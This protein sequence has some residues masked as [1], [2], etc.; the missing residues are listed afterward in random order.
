MN[1]PVGEGFDLSLEFNLGGDLSVRIVMPSEFRKPAAQ[2]LLDV[3]DGQGL[4][5]PAH[6]KPPRQAPASGRVALQLGEVVCIKNQQSLLRRFAFRDT[7]VRVGR[8]PRTPDRYGTLQWCVASPSCGWTER[9]GRSTRQ[10][11][12]PVLSRDFQESATCREDS[13]FFRGLPERNAQF[14]ISCSW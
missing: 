6:L 7:P 12:S 4:G 5:I 11:F 8:L 2:L 14:Q 9:A 1:D 10:L 13:S 3:Y